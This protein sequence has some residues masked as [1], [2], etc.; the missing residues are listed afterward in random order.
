MKKKWTR[1]LALLCTLALALTLAV[2]AFAE[3]AD[4]TE[5][6]SL[7]ENATAEETGVL[8]D[9]EMPA[10]EQEAE[11]VEKEKETDEDGFI[12]EVFVADYEWGCYDYWWKL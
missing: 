1:A 10:K 8:Q 3:E 9:G 11:P 5:D 2:P 4:G 12:H 6:D 7:P